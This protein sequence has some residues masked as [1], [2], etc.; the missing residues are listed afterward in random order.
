VGVGIEDTWGSYLWH[1]KQSNNGTSW[2]G[3][4]SDL[5]ELERLR[6]QNEKWLGDTHELAGL[7][8]MSSVIL[9]RRSRTTIGELTRHVKELRTLSSTIVPEI[10]EKLFVVAHGELVAALNGYMDDCYLEILQE[11]FQLG[12]AS[13]LPL[14]R[15][16]ANLNPTR[17]IPGAEEGVDAD[18]EAG[19]WF[20]MKGLISDIWH[21]YMFE[22][23]DSKRELLFKACEYNMDPAIQR[24]LLKQI[25]LRNCVQHHEGTVTDDAL[26]LAGVSKFVVATDDGA[27]LELQRGSKIVLSLA[28]LT[29]FTEVLSKLA[30]DF[31]AHTR[32]R[33]RRAVWVPRSFIRDT[34]SKKS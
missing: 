14:G 1:V 28:E 15:F 23:F 7:M 13:G 26:R 11:V 16:K 5:L 30:E 3:G 32:R 21:S 4:D 9:V 17:Y 6:Q 33:I 22:P 27:T 19:Q 18:E 29:N 20:T 10:V 2:L 31:D 25:Q 24:E 34:E 12:N 8:F